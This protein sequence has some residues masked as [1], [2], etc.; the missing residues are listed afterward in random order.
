MR[1]KVLGCVAAVFWA[2]FGLAASGL[3][4]ADVGDFARRDGETSDAA[5]ILRA[6]E[7]AGKGGVVW[8]PRGVYLID[9]TLAVTNGVSLRLHKSAR[10]VAAADMDFVVDYS[11]G[12]MEAGGGRP[13]A[14]HN[15]FVRGGEIDGKGRASCL[16]VRSFRRME[17]SGLTLRNGRRFGLKV[18]AKELGRTG[19]GYEAVVRDVYCICD[20]PGMAGNVGLESELSDCHFVDCF[21]IDYTVGVRLRNSSCRLA[22]CHVWGGM[23][24]NA[25]GQCEYLKDSV[26]FDLDNWDTLLDACY[27][28]T[29]KVG[30]RVRGHARIVNSAVFNNYEVFK[31]DDPLAIDHVDGNLTVANCHFVKT[32]PHARLYR[33]ASKYPLRWRDNTLVRFADKERRVVDEKLARDA[34]TS[35]EGR[36]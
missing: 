5:R 12:V 31:M 20:R 15:L 11:G 1:M 4:D 27:A 3:C 9:R 13:G 7:E 18:G 21:V 29:A 17:V 25:A 23:V 8:F 35:K 32:S 30:F 34:Q 26:A 22:R 6:V 19:G 2:A 14:D 10:L 33:G 16:R 28:D 36:R 24:R